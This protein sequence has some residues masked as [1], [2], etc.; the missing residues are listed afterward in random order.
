MLTLADSTRFDVA[1]DALSHVYR[2]RLLIEL[3]VTEEVTLAEDRRLVANGGD[4]DPDMVHQHLF[5]V[6]LP[7]L[8][9]NG[10]IEWDRESDVVRAGDRFEE[11]APMLEL[12]DAHADELPEGWL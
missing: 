2:R 7:K 12:L 4:V 9:E 3:R 1:L 6:H 10:Y 8:A 11:I 5:H